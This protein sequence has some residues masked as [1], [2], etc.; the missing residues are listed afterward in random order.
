MRHYKEARIALTGVAAMLASAG[1]SAQS[2]VTLYGVVDTGLAY[3]SNQAPSTGATSG[4][5]SVVKMIEGVWGGER[6]GLKGS[7][8]LGGGNKAIFQLEQGFNATNGTASKTGLMFSRAAWVGL[9][10]QQ[11]GVLTLG[12]QYTPYYNMTAQYGP[13]PWLT[14]AFGAHPGDLD[15]LDTDFRINNAVVYTTPS[16]YGF[17]MSGMYALGGIAGSFNAGS[18]WSVGAQYLAGPAGI[19]VGFARFNNANVNGGP[20]SSSSTAYSGTGEQGVSAITNGYQNAAAQQRF[21]V[22][23]GYQFNSKW[24]V[25]ASY[26]NVQYIPGIASGFPDTAIFNT[27]GV[28]LHFHPADP[29]DL[30]AGYAY[31]WAT[32]A[33]G[34]QDAATYSQINLTQLYSLSKR[35][36]IYLLE[37]YQ[38]ANGQTLNNGKIINATANIAEE[39]AAATR[40]QFAVTL[41]INHQF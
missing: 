25:S 9:A 31:T 15:A 1:V 5:H 33:N 10:N 29:W 24:D 11:Y 41:G 21:A 14:G 17:R 28:V 35:T 36:R 3:L 8:D 19:G 18:T 20:W 34:I 30:A 4:G 16:F 6:F 13:T 26:T 39:S 22:T 40:S 37:A 12:R 23:G 2:S 32:K 27:G 7:E 38:R